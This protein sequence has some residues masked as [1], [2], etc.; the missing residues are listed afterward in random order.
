MIVISVVAAQNNLLWLAS[1]VTIY[2]TWH[3]AHPCPEGDSRAKK[4]NDIVHASLY[5]CGTLFRR[6]GRPVRDLGP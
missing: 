4:V 1:A 6:R 3:D 2:K 5:N